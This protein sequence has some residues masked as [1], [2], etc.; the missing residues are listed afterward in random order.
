MCS[1]VQPA[2]GR[3]AGYAELA[4][5]RAKETAAEGA[6]EGEEAR[7]AVAARVP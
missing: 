1:G 7:R 5:G 2:A 6:A 4:A 3:A